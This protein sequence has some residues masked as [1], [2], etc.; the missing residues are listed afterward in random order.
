MSQVTAVDTI[1]NGGSIVTMNAQ[2]HILQDGAIAIRGQSIVAIGK[3]EEIHRDY[4]ATKTIDARND[5]VTPGFIDG[6]NHPMHYMSKG[7]IDDMPFQYRFPNVIMPYEK[8]LTDEEM[9]LNSCATFAEMLMNGTTCFNDPG[10][11]HPDAVGRAATELG[12]RGI[13][14][15][16][17]AD[18]AWG[19]TTYKGEGRAKAEVDKAEATVKKWTGAA[20]GRLRAWFCI[21]SPDRCSDGLCFDVFERAKRYGVGIH[22][23]LFVMPK[24]YKRPGFVSPVHRYKELG[25]L[26]PNLYAAHLGCIVQEDI[27]LLV[28]HGVKGVTCPGRSLFGS[29]GYIAHGTIPEMIASGMN[30]AL[31]TDAA[32]VSRFLDMVRQMYIIGCGYKDSRVDP[33]MIGAYKAFEMATID[34]A[35]GM[36]WD[37]E[38]GSLEAG[39]KAD[40]NII[41]ASV[42][43]LHPNPLRNPVQNLVY[44]GS[45]AATKTV[46]IDGKVVMEDRVLKTI[47]MP[48]LMKEVDRATDL[49][50]ARTN[51]SIKPKWPVI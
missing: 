7:S 12:I 25:L 39:K 27:D 11:F 3:R 45:G 9:Y 16:D 26:A 15:Y 19:S 6:H 37:D 17:T 34:C 42:S 43:E 44:A 22:T 47:D 51:I 5:I 10:T 31:G 21:I 46:M 30:L 14:A 50:L 18:Q 41:D 8:A 33:L 2:R 13:I 23:H 48:A 40:L 1:V 32:A 49:L 36:L 35:K 4:R 29:G 38:I 28:E 20:D 24:D